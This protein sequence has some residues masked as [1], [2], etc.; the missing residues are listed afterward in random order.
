[1]AKYYICFQNYEV[2]IM[3]ESSN[4]N[5]ENNMPQQGRNHN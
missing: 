4:E 2:H 1:M 3:N 5:E